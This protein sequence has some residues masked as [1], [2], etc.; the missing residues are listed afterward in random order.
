MALILLF[1][2]FQFS[3][4]HLYLTKVCLDFD[5]FETQEAPSLRI[6]GALVP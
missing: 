6:T 2:I 5:L 3:K 4:L 1:T